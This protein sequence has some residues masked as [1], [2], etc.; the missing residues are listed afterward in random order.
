MKKQDLVDILGELDI[1][2]LHFNYRGWAVA[3][4]PFAEFLHERGTDHSPSFNVRVDATGPSGFWCFTCKQKGR[5]SSLINRLGHYR[6]ERYN[7][8]ALKAEVMEIPDALPDFEQEPEEALRQEAINPAL[9]MAMYPLPAE[10]ED[11]VAYLK[12]RGISRKT[13]ELLELRYD[14]ERRR[15]L[16]PVFDYKRDLYGFTG[17]S[18]VP[19]KLRS[20]KVPKIKNY[21]GLRKELRLLGEQLIEKGKPIIVVEGLFALA[22]LIEIGVAKFA[23]VVA[24]MGSSLS[25]AQR[26]ALLFYDCPVYLLFDNDAAGDMGLYGLWD[27]QRQE[28]EGNGA[29]DLLSKH[30]PTFVCLYPE[31]KND[32]DELVCDDVEEMIT[33]Y[34]ERV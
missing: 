6:G 29:V 23:N 25:E 31:G 21:A 5:I 7:S 15:I 26:D 27:A 4:C 20:E 34:N 13:A 33:T 17:R 14:P 16:F 12:K 10:D 19:D 22:H 18:I 9:Y 24:V 32:P 11:A 2:V 8:L 3:R 28:Y 1:E 30:V